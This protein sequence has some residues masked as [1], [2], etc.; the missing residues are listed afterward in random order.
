ME[1]K[2]KSTSLCKIYLW[3]SILTVPTVI[4]SCFFLFYLFACN[5]EE[6]KISCTEN[7]L[8]LLIG[9]A[10]FLAAFSAI[11]IY[12]IFN[13]SVDKEKEKIVELEED[14]AKK[15]NDL[16]NEL[17]RKINKE[18]DSSKESD[19]SFKN[20]KALFDLTSPYSPPFNKRQAIFHF[21]QNPPE[22]E[23]TRNFIRNYFKS[24]GASEKKEKYYPELENLI[25]AWE[26]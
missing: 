1:K 21:S 16:S 7:Y 12:S 5:T 4:L 13:A 18:K 15:I 17:N 11:S 10:G 23:D 25:K 26:T 14:C 24:L 22:T 19:L 20:Q 2:R 9:V 3:L 6:Y 8:T